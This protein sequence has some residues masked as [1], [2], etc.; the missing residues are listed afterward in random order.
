MRYIHDDVTTSG[1]RTSQ[2]AALV[3]VTRANTDS[4]QDLPSGSPPT[5][6]LGLI[7]RPRSIAVVGAHEARGGLGKL[8]QQAVDRARMAGA[9]FF[10]VNPTKDSVFGFD[11]VP[12]LADIGHPIDV[13][14]ILTGDPISVIDDATSRGA[15][16]GF[17][18]VFA[19]K[20]RELGTVEGTERESRLAAA[21]QRAGARLIGPNTNGNAWEPLRDLPGPKI[22]LV[23]Q[24]GVQ[25]RPLTQAQDL[26]VALSF[27]APTGNEADLE[28]ADF[29][30]WFARDPG[31]S[32][33]CAY[34]EGFRSGQRLREAATAAIEHATPVVIVKVGR[35]AAGSSM[36]Q[37][38]TGHLVGSD[39]VM[40]AFFEQYGMTRV[41]D[42]D[43]WVEVATALAR[44]P[45]PASDGVVVTSV[46]G[47]TAAHLA[48]LAAA[49]GLHL[50][51]LSEET[52]TSLRRIIPDGFAVSNPVDNGGGVMR[53]GAGPDIWRLCLD[54]PSTGILL[55]PIPAASPGITEAVGD[56]LVE[57]WKTAT[58]PI[59]PIWSGPSVD[60]PTYRQLLDAGVPVFRNFRNAIRAAHALLRHP[61]R[62]AGLREVAAAARALPPVPPPPIATIALAEAEATAWL[63]RRG[64]PF[65]R[66]EIADSLDEAVAAAERIGYPVVLK[67]RGTAHKSERGLVRL[68]LRS[69]ADLRTAAHAMLEAGAP[70][71]L[72][73]RE[74][75]G[76]IELLVGVSTDPTVGPVLVLGAGGVTAE[77]V[78]DVQRAVLPVTRQRVEA[79]ISRLRIAPLLDGW[80]GAP[81]CDR[82]A[83][84]DVV[85]HLADLAA[86]G[87]IVELDI[88]PLLAKPDGVVG[89]DALVRVRERTAVSP[90]VQSGE[91]A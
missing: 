23:S 63:G 62:D 20:F 30:E 6:D 41:D 21:V 88:N 35:S 68:G 73:A 75:S 12:S 51:R 3:T 65:A 39:E 25:G 36:S 5:L 24:S 9:E 37:S 83:I 69:P 17:Y 13:A 81:A 89:L 66:S 11:C 57:L 84:V 2:G 40:D 8:T 15:K 10:A 80:R 60:H 91:R 71:F 32:V 43:E 70:G 48:D 22:A 76:G 47:G 4:S 52:Q 1:D 31:T 44:C 86:D 64:L 90:E 16:I 58:K 59:L 34:I 19:N 78:R 72:V 85:L 87:E 55:S 56:T 45:V 33:I 79:M 82:N 38:H 61:G 28:S 53:T 29:I 14:L 54:D 74:E 46:S 7:Y 26:G 27:W 77:A 49:S 18:I 42:L 50:P 67:G